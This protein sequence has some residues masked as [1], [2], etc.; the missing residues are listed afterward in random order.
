MFGF[1]RLHFQASSTWCSP[2]SGANLIRHSHHMVQSSA[3]KPTKKLTIS[4]SV[5]QLAEHKSSKN[6]ARGGWGG[7][8]EP[9][10]SEKRVSF[11]L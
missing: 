5:A 8:I 3:G 9:S 10:L 2:D 11:K 7:Y 4:P 6:C 1:G